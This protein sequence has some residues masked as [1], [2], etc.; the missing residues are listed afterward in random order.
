MSATATDHAV[1]ESLE[2]A[3]NAAMV[4]NDVTQI[5]ACI[6]RDWVLVTPERGPV[7]GRFVLDA[8]DNK[9]LQHDSMTKH[10]HRVAVYGDNAIVTGRG[11]NTGTFRGQPIAADEWT[12]DVDPRESGDR[13]VCVPTHLTPAGAP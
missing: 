5:A 1:F 2:Q 6:S 4:S 7:D 8:I 3:F 11:Q 10:V 13:W 9:R 12:T